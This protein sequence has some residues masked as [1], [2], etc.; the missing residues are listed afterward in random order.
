MKIQRFPSNP[1]IQPG[2]HP[3]TGTNI[4]GPSLIRVPDWIPNPLGRYYLY[5]AHH[6]G[7][8]IR[9]AYADRIQG[10]WQ[11]YPPGALAVSQ[12]ACQDHVASPD[13]HID[14]AARRICMYFHGPVPGATADHPIAA[15]QLSFAATS[16]DGLHFTARPQPLGNPYFRVFTWQGFTYAL[17]M[18][19]IFYRSADGLSG[20]EK[21]PTLFTSAMRHSAL[22]LRGHTLHVFYSNA[23]D[24]PERILHAAIDLRPDWNAW[25]TAPPETVL[26]PELAYEGAGLS[27]VPSRRGWASEPVRELRDPAIFEEDG[28]TYLLYSIAGEAGLA[29]AEVLE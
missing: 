23:G 2:M 7:E 14:E 26:A 12:T 29:G 24:C 27:L 28:R 3:A 15:G 8:N 16:E 11:I 6:H 4:N 5:F 19:G 20:F 21:G 18:P 9:L 10:P 1:L 25:Q 17:G 22:W 13:V